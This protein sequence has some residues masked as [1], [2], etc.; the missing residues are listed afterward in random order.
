MGNKNTEFPH[1]LRGFG[2]RDIREY[3]KSANT[4]TPPLLIHT[5]QKHF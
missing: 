4:E 2:T 1:Y 3:A 5:H